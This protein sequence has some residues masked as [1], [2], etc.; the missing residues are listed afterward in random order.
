MIK[1][2]WSF[3][4]TS[5]MCALRYGE[6]LSNFLMLTISLT[7]SSSKS[8]KSRSY[9]SGYWDRLVRKCLSTVRFLEVYESDG[10]L[11][12]NCKFVLLT[13]DLAVGCFTSSFAYLGETG[14]VF[15]IGAVV[16]LIFLS[17]DTSSI[18]LCGGSSFNGDLIYRDTPEVVNYLLRPLPSPTLILDR[19][20]S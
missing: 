2:F 9:S 6:K 18:T 3:V 19:Y 10:L 8:S 15:N 12:V 13:I 4:F 7:W 16:T 11:P 5:I 1:S 20:S 14:S 17:L